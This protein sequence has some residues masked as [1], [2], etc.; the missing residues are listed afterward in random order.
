M[1]EKKINLFFAKGSMGN[2][3]AFQDRLT[4]IYIVDIS[5]DII[6]Y[7]NNVDHGK[8]SDKYMASIDYKHIPRGYKTLTVITQS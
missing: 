2:M 3:N 8:I 4:F 6:L 7:E 1:Q 5:R